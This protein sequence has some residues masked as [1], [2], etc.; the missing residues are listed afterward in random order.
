MRETN[1][2]VRIG[3]MLALGDLV[4]AEHVD[5]A[6]LHEHVRCAAE[7]YFESSVS[8]DE[9]AAVIEGYEVERSAME[10]RVAT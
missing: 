2:L 9:L 6:A 4:R 1:Q 3:E 7:R 5:D 10:R 8:E